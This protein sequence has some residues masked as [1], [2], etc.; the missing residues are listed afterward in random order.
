[1]PHYIFNAIPTDES[2]ELCESLI[3]TCKSTAK[4]SILRNTFASGKGKAFI[5]SIGLGCLRDCKDTD[6]VYILMHG[7]GYGGSSNVGVSR[8]AKKEY[9]RGLPV[10]EGGTLKAYNVTSL[11]RALSKEGLPKSFQH[12]HLLTCGSGFAGDEETHPNHKGGPVPP[13]VMAPLAKRLK[14]ALVALGYGHIL[15]TGYKG[16]ISVN[17]ERNGWFSVEVRGG[18][19]VPADEAMVT[20]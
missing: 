20:F 5:R 16:D 19:F 13:E 2:T 8:G 12:L 18:K 7:S 3:D 15:V 11:A 9:K 14:D 10:W 4:L 17:I 6:Y 1:M